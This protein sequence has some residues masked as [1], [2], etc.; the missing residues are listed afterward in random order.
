MGERCKQQIQ[1]QKIHKPIELSLSPPHWSYEGS[2]QPGLQL[3][4][5]MRSNQED[6]TP[7][8][9]IQY[10]SVNHKKTIVTYHVE[11]LV[12]IF[13]FSS[14]FFISTGMTNLDEHIISSIS[15][16]F[17]SLQGTLS[18]EIYQHINLYGN[19]QLEANHGESLMIFIWV[20]SLS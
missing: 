1:D 9:T 7:I 8:S 13:L 12:Q 14:F 6:L 17:V 15:C 16:F 5:T 3:P 11:K 20:P 10:W 18:K 19:P 4:V 2:R